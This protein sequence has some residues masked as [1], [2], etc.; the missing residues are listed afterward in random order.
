[1]PVYVNTDA[2]SFKKIIPYIICINIVYERI[3]MVIANEP[4]SREIY[5]RSEAEAYSTA[6]MIPQ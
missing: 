2:F 6:D 1:M 3:S 4:H 5:V